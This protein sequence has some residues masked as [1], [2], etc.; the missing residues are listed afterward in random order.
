[1]V[2]LPAAPDLGSMTKRDAVRAA[3]HALGVREA[4]RA[5][6]WLSDRGVSVS[7]REAQRVARE[8]TRRARPVLAALPGGAS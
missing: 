3:F 1:V 5:V 6:E 8:D 4:S 7:R 2:T